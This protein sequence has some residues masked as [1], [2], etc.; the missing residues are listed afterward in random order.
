MKTPRSVVAL[1][2][3][4]LAA[5]S[6]KEG[7]REAAREAAPPPPVLAGVPFPATARLTDTTR[8]ADALRAQF[9]VGMS[10]DSL[11][12]YYRRELPKA[13]FRIVGDV[14][15]GPRVDMYAQRDGP[16]LWV[17]MQPARDSGITQF[18]IIGAAAGAPARPEPRDTLGR[19]AP[20]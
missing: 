9:F 1:L 12:A 6:V 7:A 8:T 13:G 5:C 11:A 19:R 16:P 3:V 10:V 20:R 17:Q 15:D 2:G 14:T 18:T 4:A